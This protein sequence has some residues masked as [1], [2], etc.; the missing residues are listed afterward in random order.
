MSKDNRQVIRTGSPV[1]PIVVGAII[2][3]LILMLGFLIYAGKINLPMFG[4]SMT[5]SGTGINGDGSGTNAG[6]G[7]TNSTDTGNSTSGASG[8]DGTSGGNGTSGSNGTNGSTSGGNSGTG[9]LNLRVTIDPNKPGANVKADNPN[10]NVNVDTQ[11]PSVNG[12][13]V[14]TGL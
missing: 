14:N 9:G 11:N 4:S 13:G 6:N 8:S 5:K 2:I 12:N 1:T 7:S 3:I 10:T